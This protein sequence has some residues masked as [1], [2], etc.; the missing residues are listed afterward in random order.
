MARL[1]PRDLFRIA[2]RTSLLQATWNYERQQGVGWAY[3]IR[4]A[5]ERLIANPR[6]R[7]ER[8]A[9]HTAYFN[10]QPTLASVALGAVARLEEERA[11]GEGPDAAGIARVKSA[12]GSS[13]A[14]VGDRLFWF[15]LRPF[16]ACVG[17]LFALGGPWRGALALWV[18]YNAVHLTVRLRGVRWGYEGGPSF[19]GAPL[20]VPL[21]RLTR[22]AALGGCVVV[23]A[24]IAAL[25]VPGGTPRPLVFQA[26]LVAGITVG[27]IVAP[28]PRPSP[29]E[30]AL[31]AAV[32]CVV[33]AWMRGA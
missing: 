20:R 4:P 29:T 31:G 13:L 33:A 10:T 27:F 1:T 23:A 18:C 9:E 8:L 19:A 30:W 6:T 7:C 28:R 26:V 21:E 24:L 16:A 15:T 3:A 25:L 11:A 22:L 12:L 2:L 32:L 5:L 14:A 17:A